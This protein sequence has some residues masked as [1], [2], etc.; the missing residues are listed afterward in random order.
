MEKIENPAQYEAIHSEGPTLVIAGPV[1]GRPIP[2]SR[3]SF[4]SSVTGR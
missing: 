2:L 1:P 3:E 4:T